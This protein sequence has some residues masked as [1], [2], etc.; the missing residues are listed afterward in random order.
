VAI[1]SQTNVYITG[2]FHNTTT[3]GTNVLSAP[4]SDLFLAKYDRDGNCLWARAG[5]SPTDAVGRSLVLDG[6]GNVIVTGAFV[7]SLF[8]GTNLLT[9]TGGTPNY[10]VFVAK[11]AANGT[12]LWSRKGG[13][14]FDDL[15]GGVGADSANN[16]YVTGYFIDQATFGTNVVSRPATKGIFL[17]KYDS[18]GALLWIR[19]SQASDADDDAAIAVDAGGSSYITGG[20]AGT[21][22][23][24]GSI[25]VTNHNTKSDVFVVKYDANGNPVWARGAGG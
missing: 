21:N 18:N 12:L 6:N 24:F 15:G 13:G 5:G 4:Q 8:S 16:Y 22:I 2:Y 25:R 17:A 3:F 11:Y 1:D 9:G 10:D 20:F 7:T 19:Q 14:N 23:L